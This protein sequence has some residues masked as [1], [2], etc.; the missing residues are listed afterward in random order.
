MISSFARNV[1]NCCSY[2]NTPTYDL[3][4][5]HVTP[6]YILNCTLITWTLQS[7]HAAG[8]AECS[9]WNK[10]IYIRDNSYWSRYF[11]WFYCNGE[12]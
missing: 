10:Q 3:W 4:H 6:A 5:L 1:F 11:Y 12:L 7:S 2:F 9:I 8:T